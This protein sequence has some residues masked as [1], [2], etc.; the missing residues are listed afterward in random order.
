MN[1]RVAFDTHAFVKRLEA[2]GMSVPH[3]E[4][5]ADAMGDIVLQSITTKTDLRE[6]DIGLRAEMKE[7]ST[8]LRSEMKELSTSFRA[9]MNAMEIRLTIR[10][11]AMAAFVVAVVSAL[12][13]F[14]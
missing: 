1:A 10:M 11:A 4:A 14:A 13:I 9:E 3:A 8:S 12:K 2:A 7:L 5:L 6:V